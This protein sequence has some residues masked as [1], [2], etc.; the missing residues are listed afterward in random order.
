VGIET[1]LDPALTKSDGLAGNMAG[2]PGT[3]PPTCKELTLEYH[4][5]ERVVGI[6]G[7]VKVTR[8]NPKEPLVLNSYS[9][10]TSGTV[11]SV[12]PERLEIR[13][14]RPLVAKPSDRVTIS[15][16]IGTGWRLIGYGKIAG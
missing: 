9:A 5:F 11:T 8:I 16:K 6:D 2:K 12:T 3:L 1:D 4:L 7:E 15:R 10:V 14:T 13:L